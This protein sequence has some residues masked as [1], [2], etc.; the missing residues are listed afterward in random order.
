[1][2]IDSIREFCLS[3]PHA[4]ESVQWDDDL[5]M[6]IGGKMFAIIALQPRPI[7]IAFKCTPD[8]F[9]ELVERPAIIPSPYLARHHWV[10]LQTKDALTNSEIKDYLRRSYALV[11]ETLPKKARA[12]LVTSQKESRSRAMAK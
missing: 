1:M 11:L 2:T 4:T 12:A 8:D 3:L 9:A 6:K 7:W 10:A 5:V